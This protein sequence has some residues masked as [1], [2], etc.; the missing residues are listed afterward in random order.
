V[1]ASHPSALQATLP[2]L[3]R[4]ELADQ[5]ASSVLHRASFGRW[6]DCVMAVPALVCSVYALPVALLVGL[7]VLPLNTALRLI[8]GR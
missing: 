5:A 4:L 7:V 6:G 2:W 8:L 3:R 1:V